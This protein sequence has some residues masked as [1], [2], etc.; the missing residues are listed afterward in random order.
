MKI[1]L[2]DGQARGTSA[3]VNTSLIAPKGLGNTDARVTDDYECWTILGFGPVTRARTR[4]I[5]LSLCRIYLPSGGGKL[6]RQTLI[7]AVKDRK[8]WRA[9]SCRE[10]T[11]GRRRI[12]VHIF[13]TTIMF[14]WTVFHRKKILMLFIWS[15]LLT[16]LFVVWRTFRYMYSHS[17]VESLLIYYRIIKS[18]LEFLPIE[19]ASNHKELGI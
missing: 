13:N 14:V 7:R 15:W 8:F 19:T 16:S 10:T 17:I 9:M 5:K 11:H 1:L 4:H 18:R 6:K 3:H 12:S 2:R